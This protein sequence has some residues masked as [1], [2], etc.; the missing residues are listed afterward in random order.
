MKCPDL[1]IDVA[2]MEKTSSAVMIPFISGWND[3][4]TWDKV[5]EVSKKNQNGNSIKGKVFEEKCSDSLI[6]SQ[7]RLIAALGIKNLIIVET[8]DA[9]LISSKSES[10]NIKTLVEKL[11]SEHIEEVENHLKMF[12]LGKL[13]INRG[14]KNLESKKL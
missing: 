10:Q 2:V 12:D 5:W 4:G 3:I 1:S 11:K 9:L 8:K 6:F 14:I 13:H 7:D